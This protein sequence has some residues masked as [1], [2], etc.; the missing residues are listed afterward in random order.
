MDIEVFPFILSF[1]F[2]LPVKKC[3][4]FCTLRCFLALKCPTTLRQDKKDTGKGGSRVP[5]APG[6]RQTFTNSPPLAAR[7]P[8]KDAQVLDAQAHPWAHT[9]NS[10][11]KTMP[12]WFSSLLLARSHRRCTLFQASPRLT[13]R[14]LRGYKGPTAASRGGARARA[15]RGSSTAG[16]R[17]TSTLAAEARRR[18]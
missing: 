11:G 15:P 14:G 6:T 5:K 16:N 10:Q 3:P 9:R 8:V 4:F 12:V 7:S 17:T 13:A 18:L 2:P 1:D